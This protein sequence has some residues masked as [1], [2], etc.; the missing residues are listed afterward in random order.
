MARHRLY[1]AR[2]RVQLL[3]RQILSADLCV[4]FV[5]AFDDVLDRKKKYDVTH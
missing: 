4:L 3:N 2:Q 1:G 5:R